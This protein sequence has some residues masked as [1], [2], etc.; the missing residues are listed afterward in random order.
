[1]TAVILIVI[2][3]LVMRGAN[4]ISFPPPRGER[5]DFKKERKKARQGNPEIV[6]GDKIT[7]SDLALSEFTGTASWKEF[8][9]KHV[10]KVTNVVYDRGD[11]APPKII[12]NNASYLEFF[13]ARKLPIETPEWH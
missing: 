11:S 13:E 12:I 9:S 7:Y 8:L 10:F 5:Y 2:F 4:S 6:I 3:Y 1:M